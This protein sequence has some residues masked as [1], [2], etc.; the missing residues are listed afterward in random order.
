MCDAGEAFQVMLCPSDSTGEVP[1]QGWADPEAQRYPIVSDFVFASWQQPSC[2]VPL[3]LTL[4]CCKA[5][6]RV[7]KCFQQA[8]YLGAMARA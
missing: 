6:Q 7:G 4:Y 2:F 8:Q 3:L 5:L 1:E